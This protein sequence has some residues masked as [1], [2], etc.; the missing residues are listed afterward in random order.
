MSVLDKIFGKR[1]QKTEPVIEE[2]KTAS[3]DELIANKKT[4]FEPEI[5]MFELENADWRVFSAWLKSKTILP[6]SYVKKPVR[7]QVA[8]DERKKPMVLLTFVSET[9]DSV[10]E[11]LLMQDDVSQSINGVVNGKNDE[12]IKEIWLDFQKYLRRKHAMEIG[13]DA[14]RCKKQGEELKRKA[15]RMISLK[16][17]PDLEREFL[18]RY[19]NVEFDEF[20]GTRNGMRPPEFTIYGEGGLNGVQWVAPFSPKTLEFCLTRLSEEGKVE[21]GFDI[22]IFIKKCQ[23]IKVLSGYESK[24]WD[25]VIGYGKKLV[26]E[27]WERAE[28]QE[29]EELTNG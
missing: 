16:I 4:S 1:K 2:S 28:F 29:N 27:A 25:K 9:S 7:V 13:Q 3:V 23:Q 6:N 18:E 20:Y 5:S 17:L 24:D 11:I 8:I 21:E 14:V 22:D 10:R 15:E 26:M 19:Q 12:Q